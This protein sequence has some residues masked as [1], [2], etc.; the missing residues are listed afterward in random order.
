[1][2]DEEGS[3]ALP[4]VLIQGT[5]HLANRTSALNHE[6]VQPLRRAV[7]GGPE[8]GRAPARGL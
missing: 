5:F 7:D 8:P 2:A 4:F 3:M 1:M 6:R